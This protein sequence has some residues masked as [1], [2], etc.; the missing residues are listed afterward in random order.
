LYTDKI[1]QSIF[2]ENAKEYKQILKLSE[3]EK[4]RQI[5]AVLSGDSCE[6]CCFHGTIYFSVA[7]FTNSMS[8]L[9]K[10]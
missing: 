3:K 5:L 1:Y 4:F 9:A 7:K 2:R 6:E 10:F 8:L